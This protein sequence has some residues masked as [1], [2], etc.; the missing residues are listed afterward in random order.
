MAGVAAGCRLLG[1]R[2]WAARSDALV[3]SLHA[4]MAWAAV[5]LAADRRADLGAPIPEVAGLHALT[6]GAMGL[7]ILAVMTRVGLGHTGRPLTLPKGAVA[8]YVLVQI[9]AL[10]RVAAPFFA[11]E[12]QRL[13]LV[14]A[15]LAW[16]GAFG[17]FAVLYAPILTRPRI[18]AKPG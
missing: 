4:G 15:S 18:D 11:G 2:G 14:S 7:T 5:G 3:W 13:L 8:S 12:H 1:W 17:W 16:A 6:A 10:L 9:G